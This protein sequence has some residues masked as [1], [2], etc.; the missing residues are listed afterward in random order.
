MRNVIITDTITYYY[1][2]GCFDGLLP[3]ALFSAFNNIIKLEAGGNFET[4][5]NVISVFDLIKGF[6]DNINLINVRCCSSK[7]VR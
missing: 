6:K 5:I 7:P 3:I 4:A 1:E 2:F